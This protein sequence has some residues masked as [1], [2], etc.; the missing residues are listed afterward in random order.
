[1]RNQI[2]RTVIT[3]A[4]TVGSLLASSASYEIFTK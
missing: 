2:R 1:M 3:I 4:L